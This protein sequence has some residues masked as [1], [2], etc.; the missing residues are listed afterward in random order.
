VRKVIA[1][2]ALLIALSGCGKSEEA[3]P[4][5]DP[6]ATVVQSEREAAKKWN[7]RAD[8]K[9]EPAQVI[10]AKLEV[11]QWAFIITGNPNCFSSDRLALAKSAITIIESSGN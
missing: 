6:C 4:V 8:K 9:V 11:L 5:V 7:A 3:T 1:F 10:S 2:I